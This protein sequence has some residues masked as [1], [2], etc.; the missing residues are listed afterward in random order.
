LELKVLILL[1]CGTEDIVGCGRQVG[2]YGSCRLYG[3]L[4]GPI[5]G[6]RGR[7]IC[8][9]AILVKSQQEETREQGKETNL[10]EIVDGVAIS[11]A[12]LANRG[13]AVL[14]GLVATIE[15]Y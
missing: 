5:G 6:C 14:G 1:A 10:V 11:A 7:N 13:M 3:V 15:T 4:L 9:I 2:G 12:E 8:D